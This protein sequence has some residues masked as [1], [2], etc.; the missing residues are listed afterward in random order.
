MASLYEIGEAYGESCAIISARIKELRQA[1]KDEWDPS[2]RRRIMLRI[3]SL[4]PIQRDMRE[5]RDI[6]KNY[7]TKGGKRSVR[8]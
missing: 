8:E 1:A 7:Y 5:L 2:V 4:T 3:N 6:C